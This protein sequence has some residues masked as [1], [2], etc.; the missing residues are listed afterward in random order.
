M[1]AGGQYQGMASGMFTVQYRCQVREYWYDAGDTPDI[2]QAL[3]IA[4]R[5]V[6]AGRRVRIL[7]DSGFIVWHSL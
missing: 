3:G 5:L 4:Y 1:T 2:T 6:Q 7:D